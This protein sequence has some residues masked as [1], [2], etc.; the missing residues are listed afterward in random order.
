MSIPYTEDKIILSPGERR[1]RSLSGNKLSLYTST[2]PVEIAFGEQTEFFPVKAG[3]SIPG[4][5]GGFKIVRF[6]NPGAADITVEFAVSI[7]D[8]RPFDV[9]ISNSSPL[10][11]SNTPVISKTLATGADVPCAAGGSTQLRGATPG[12]K[13]VFISNLA[14]NT[15]TMRIGNA[16]V[17]AAKG[18]PIAPG[19]TLIL[20]VEAAV[21]AWNPGAVIESVAITVIMT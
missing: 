19:E 1:T 12:V 8:V 17:G 10:N 3:R 11:T 20:S 14:T 7:S 5:D 15:A 16:A 4:P 13:E 6:Y 21:F 9:I 18:I 2:G